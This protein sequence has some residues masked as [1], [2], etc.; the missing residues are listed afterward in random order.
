M[1]T[2]RPD[3]TGPDAMREIVRRLRANEISE[4]Y[5]YSRIATALRAEREAGTQDGI[6]LV[7]KWIEYSEIQ[8]TDDF[9]LVA[10]IRSLLKPAPQAEKKEGV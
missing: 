6:E 10:R 5:A 1:T 9:D 4:N 3:W 2:S 7:A 8:L